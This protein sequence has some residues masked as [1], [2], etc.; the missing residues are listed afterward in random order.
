VALNV[1]GLEQVAFGSDWAGQRHHHLLA[2][3]VDRRVRHLSEQLKS[4]Q[5]KS[6]KIILKPFYTFA[7]VDK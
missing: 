3:R 6:V 1:A 4:E 2:E 5:I 7:F